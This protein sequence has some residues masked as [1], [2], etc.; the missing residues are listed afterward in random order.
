LQKIAPN[1]IHNASISP[2]GQPGKRGVILLGEGGAAANPSA[3]S[4][5]QLRAVWRFKLDSR[6]TEDVLHD[7]GGIATSFDGEEVLYEK[8]PAAFIAG[9][10]EL[11]VGGAD[12]TPGKSLHVDQMRAK[13]DPRLEW[14][15]MYAETWRIEREFF[16]DPGFHGLDLKKIE[17]KYAPYLD[18][19]SRRSDLTY[20]QNEMLGELTVGHMF[21]DG[22]HVESDAPKN[23]LLGAD[24]AIEGDRYKFAHI[25]SGGNWST[26]LYSPLTQP[27]V[28]VS[29]GQ[30]LLAVNGKPLHATDNL[31]AALEGWRTSR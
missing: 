26:K 27:G 3:Q 16:Y 28:G 19:L 4:G 5:A 7:V 10:D 17:A 23:G 13:I 6:K 22:P 11:A 1:E 8:G 15:Q 21:I 2:T 29:E 24:Y 31:D 25:V 9:I 18:G 14:K 30:F 12:G 20:L